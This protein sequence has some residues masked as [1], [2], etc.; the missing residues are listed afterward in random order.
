MN[1]LLNDIQD[2]N[3]PVSDLLRRAKV[4]ATKSEQADFLKWID[5]EL[6][7]YEK[8]SVFPEYRDVSGEAMALNPYRGW[9]PVLF[10]TSEIERNVSHC[11]TTQSVCEIEELLRNYTGKYEIP[12]QASTAAQILSGSPYKTKVSLFL[13]STELVK[14][15]SAVRD[16]LL[17]WALKMEKESPHGNDSELAPEKEVQT[18]STIAE[19]VSVPTV[20]RPRLLIQNADQA[21][22]TK[23]GFLQLF[24]GDK[25]RRIAGIET[26]QFR[27]IRCLFS[28]SGNADAS[29]TPVFQSC[30]RVYEAIA[31]AK[32]KSNARLKDLATKESAMY[33]IIENT[34]KEIQ[35]NRGVREYLRFDW[36][37]DKVRIQVIPPEGNEKES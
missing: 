20:F 14:I 11:P 10:K 19:T 27:L 8:G 18:V 5:L 13:G 26:R 29:F 31:L 12:F 34:I 16:T 37:A 33:D 6:N 21:G 23:I 35:K 4:L 24:D 3:V 28:S 15:L 7:G 32:D 36:S 1:T 30:E 22:K 25:K 2:K 9:L 17:D